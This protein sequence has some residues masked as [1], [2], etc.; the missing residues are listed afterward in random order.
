M[1]VCDEC[2]PPRPASG[3][4]PL[5]T[6]STRPS[7]P[8]VDCRHG[9]G[10]R[11]SALILTARLFLH[12]GRRWW[13][14]LLVPL[15]PGLCARAAY[16][17]LLHFFIHPL[18]SAIIS[19]SSL[20]LLLLQHLPSIPRAFASCPSSIHLMSLSFQLASFRRRINIGCTGP[21]VIL[22]IVSLSSRKELLQP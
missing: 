22:P 17:C 8:H 2:P 12:A 10:S 13:C 1:T 9:G 16:Y 4:R 6:L 3:N 21:S 20:P 14:R 5:P 18:S 19:A 15:P 11:P 7:R